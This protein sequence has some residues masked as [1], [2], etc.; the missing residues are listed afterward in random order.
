MKKNSFDPF[1]IN[2]FSNVIKQSRSVSISHG[3]SID[4]DLMGMTFMEKS[5]SIRVPKV[6]TGLVVFIDSESLGENNE[7]GYN[8]M[9]SFCISIANGLEL[10]EYIF[11]INSGVKLIVDEN[12]SDEFKKIKKYGTNVITSLESMK[13]FELDNVKMVQKWAIGD[14]TAVLMNANKVIKL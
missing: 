4:N 2:N 1:M 10:P 8:L 3:D 5:S 6:R 12:L 14:I 9:K 11:L 13:F 7:L